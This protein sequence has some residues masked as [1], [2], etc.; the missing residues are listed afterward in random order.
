MLKKFLYQQDFSELEKIDW[1][2]Q[3][4]HPMTLQGQLHFPYE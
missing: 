4:N 1:Q 2:F 3:E